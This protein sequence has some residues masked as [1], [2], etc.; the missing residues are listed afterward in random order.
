MLITLGIS[1]VATVLHV[2][3]DLPSSQ[4]FKLSLH[5]QGISYGSRDAS[6]ESFLC[7]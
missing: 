2:P 7:N 5:G 3:H 1:K 4:A 6:K